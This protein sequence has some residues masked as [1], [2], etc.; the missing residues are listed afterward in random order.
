MCIKQEQGLRST[1]NLWPKN[2]VANSSR[3]PSLLSMSAAVEVT[4]GLSESLAA[5]RGGLRRGVE[6]RALK[7]NGFASRRNK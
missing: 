7:A 2:K 6:L 4:L 3:T 5:A 1:F